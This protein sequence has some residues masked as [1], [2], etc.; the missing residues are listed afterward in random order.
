MPWKVRAVALPSSSDESSPIDRDAL[1]DLRGG[2]ELLALR[3]FGDHAIAEEIAQDA[4]ARAIAAAERGT[5]IRPGGTA[6]FVA[7]IARHVIIDRRRLIGREA[8]LSAADAVPAT[9]ADPLERLLAADEAAQVREALATLTPSDRELLRLSYYEGRAPAEIAA[10]TGEP[11]ERIRK[12]KSRALERLREL[13]ESVRG[14]ARRP[15]PTE[16]VHPQPDSQDK[17]P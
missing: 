13:L 11:S 17:S 3:A 4:L 1:E 15:A 8:P 6:A 9:G 7:G 12:R 16:R 14:H 5:L 2:L 10:L